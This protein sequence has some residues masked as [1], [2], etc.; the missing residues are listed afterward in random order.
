MG[1]MVWFQ[2]FFLLCMVWFGFG[3]VLKPLAALPVGGARVSVRGREGDIWLA[4]LGGPQEGVGP[5]G[6]KEKERE[7]HMGRGKKEKG[8]R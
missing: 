2:L 1:W 6:K 3:A 4:D 5:V 8:E 7:R